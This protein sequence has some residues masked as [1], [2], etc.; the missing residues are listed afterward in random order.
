MAKK[1]NRAGRPQKAGDRYACGKL[2]PQTVAPNERVERER[3]ALVGDSGADIATASDPLDFALARGFLS[4]P[5]HRAATSFAEAYER[6]KLGAPSLDQGG[7]QEASTTVEAYIERH[8]PRPRNQWDM[9][10]AAD[11]ARVF[12]AVFNVYGGS[13]E[14]AELVAMVRWKAV[15]SPLTPEEQSEL[16]AVCVRRSWPQWSI[17]KASGR[18]VPEVWDRKRRMLE[19]GL[20]KVT[21]ALRELAAAKRG[22]RKPPEDGPAASVTQLELEP[23]PAAGRKVIERLNFVDEDG[24][25]LQPVSEHGRP[26]EVERRVRRG[27]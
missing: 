7:P 18:E 12:D 17:I 25:P 19:V 5:R 13:P 2:K 11:V 23:V 15:M 4:V 6:A 3:R 1:R 22:E 24:E 8:H 20:D 21:A 16:M 27:A 10:N 9:M 26:F 14:E